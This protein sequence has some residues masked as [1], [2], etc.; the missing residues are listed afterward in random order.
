MPA[1][2]LVCTGVREVGAS[3]GSHLT[4]GLGPRLRPRDGAAPLAL[5]ASLGGREARPAT[6]SEGAPQLCC[7]NL[8]S[9][10]GTGR[11]APAVYRRPRAD[12]G[13]SETVSEE[14]PLLFSLGAGKKVGTYHAIRFAWGWMS[15]AVSPFTI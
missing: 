12:F 9:F 15:R 7:S 11:T 6:S 13:A 5:S 2:T 4:R 3:A 8:L 14:R 10:T 1:A